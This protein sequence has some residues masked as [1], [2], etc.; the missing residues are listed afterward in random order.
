[1]AIDPN[2]GM[3]TGSIGKGKPTTE[4]PAGAQTLGVPNATGTTTGSIGANAPTTEIPVGAR[5]LGT[6]TPTD[7]GTPPV[8]GAP[9]TATAGTETVSMAATSATAPT[10]PAAPV[11]NR[12]YYRDLGYTDDQI[13]A[14]IF[15]QKVGMGP[16]D[17]APAGT[18]KPTPATPTETQV[19]KLQPTAPLTP[20]TAISTAEQAVTETGKAAEEKAKAIEE[21]GKTAE[22]SAT[23]AVSAQEQY[24][25]DQEA[26]AAAR[27][28]ELNAQVAEYDR[29]RKESLDRWTDVQNTQLE[30]QK[31]KDK[32]AIEQAKAQAEEAVK[33][34]EVEND[35][36]KQTAAITLNKLGLTMSTAGITQI[37]QVFQQGAIKIARVRADNAFRVA[38]LEVLANNLETENAIKINEAIDKYTKDVFDYKTKAKEDIYGIQNDLTKT[39]RDKELAIAEIKNSYAQFKIGNQQA[40]IDTLRSQNDYVQ[41]QTDKIKERMDKIKEEKKVEVTNK[42]TSGEWTKMSAEDKK[43]AA[44]AAGLTVE[45][46]EANRINKINEAVDAGLK[47]AIV[48]IPVSPASFNKVLADAIAAANAGKPLALAIND[49]IRNN[50]N[51]LPEYA[52]SVDLQKRKATAEVG[53]DEAAITLTLANAKKA[54]AD[55]GLTN[56]QISKIQSEVNA[57]EGDNLQILKD[58]YGGYVIFNK[59]TGK[60]T[61]ANPE[62]VGSATA[63][64]TAVPAGKVGGG[65]DV[66]DIVAFSQKERGKTNLQCGEF[67]NDYFKKVTGSGAGIGDSLES[68]RDALDKIGKVDAPVAGGIFVS[69][70]NSS[71]GHTGVVKSVNADGSVTVV[72]ANAE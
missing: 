39:K 12:Q 57:K 43:K 8:A 54:L 47:A 56:A 14:A 67:V 60:V 69:N 55:I 18:P 72:E 21:A 45:Q 49:A 3:E 51:S 2:T 61:Q 30:T 44:E 4:I 53:K 26:L 13:D 64:T 9:I 35:I 66:N 27:I 7:A 32:A 58:D 28:A 33:Q 38:E 10:A 42:V 22:E 23:Q 71:Y 29:L 16:L 48:G 25:K 52:Q 59:S 1:M 15:S 41:A 68:K 63:T 62:E 46:V 34:A 17:V 5:T 65:Y 40:L 37:Q 50:L 24:A 70:G 6:A 11:K 19:G 31:A 36:A 20:Q